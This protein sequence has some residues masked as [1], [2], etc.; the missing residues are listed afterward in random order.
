MLYAIVQAN[1]Q[2]SGARMGIAR[3]TANSQDTKV[4]YW[5]FSGHEILLWFSL[6]QRT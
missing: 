3:I 2:C 4:L 1:N 5:I 6:L